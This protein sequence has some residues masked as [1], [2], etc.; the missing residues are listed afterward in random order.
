MIHNSYRQRTLELLT[1]AQRWFAM[2]AFRS[3]RMEKLKASEA[4]IA[5]SS[6]IGQARALNE[7]SEPENRVHLIAF[8]DTLYTMVY[9]AHERLWTGVW[10]RSIST[11]PNVPIEK[12][13]RAAWEYWETS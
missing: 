9:V 4:L 13:T 10:P 1:M 12:W 2:A 3:A 6:C 5:A 11:K 8:I 7:Y